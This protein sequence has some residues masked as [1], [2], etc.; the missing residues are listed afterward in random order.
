MNFNPLISV[1]ANGE[2]ISGAKKNEKSPPQVTLS[3]SLSRRHLLWPPQSSSRRQKKSWKLFDVRDEMMFFCCV[4]RSGHWKIFY[5][6]F[7][8][9]SFFR[10][11]KSSVCCFW[12]AIMKSADSATNQ[13]SALGL[14]ELL[15]PSLPLPSSSHHQNLHTTLITREKKAISRTFSSLI[16]AAWDRDKL[17]LLRR[18]MIF[19]CVALP[20]IL[21]HISHSDIFCHNTGR[22]QATH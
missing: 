22:K 16:F 1:S 15:P 9:R 21:P 6:R 17:A 11:K 13:T 12:K 4:L 20:Q 5:V 14:K 7:F 3:C 8:Y 19:F 10:G 2:R 18:S